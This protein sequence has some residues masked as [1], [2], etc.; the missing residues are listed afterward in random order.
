MT[1]SHLSEDTEIFAGDNAAAL[2]RNLKLEDLVPDR[3]RAGF[4]LVNAPLRE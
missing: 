2:F 3:G 1:R 4:C